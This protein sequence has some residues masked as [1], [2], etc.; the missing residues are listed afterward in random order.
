[1]AVDQRSL[2]L[3]DPVV[4]AARDELGAG[5][6]PGDRILVLRAIWR[7]LIIGFALQLS[8]TGL[9]F[10]QLITLYSVAGTGTLTV[11]DLG[12]LLGRSPSAASRIATGLERQGLLSRTEE[13]ADRR[14]R[15]LALTPRGAAVLAMFDRARAD[16]FLAVVRPLALADRAV[17]AMAVGALA[18]KA[19]TRSGR[20]IKA[21]PLD[22]WHGR[23]AARCRST[24]IA[25]PMRQ[26]LQR[27]A[28]RTAGTGRAEAPDG[29][30]VL[31]GVIAGPAR[32]DARPSMRTQARRAQS[33]SQRST[34]SVTR[35]SRSMSR[36]RASDR[37]SVDALGLSSMG[38]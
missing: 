11:A 8:D 27:V 38:V 33:S 12:E 21:A 26:L 35:G 5:G 19:M 36:T 20:L 24:A 4:Q 16:Q 1:M 34:R 29:G 17:V 9:G 25:R 7:D 6:L 10:V 37:G 28:S 14:Q 13:V 31:V 18:T 3:L 30:R 2:G 22:A 15:V 32:V 23:P